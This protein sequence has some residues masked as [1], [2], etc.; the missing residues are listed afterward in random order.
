MCVWNKLY[1]RN[2]YGEIEFQNGKNFEDIAIMHRI[3]AMAERIAVVDYHGYHYRQR[4]DSI[5]LT[6]TASNLLDYADANLSRYCYFEQFMKSLFIQEHEKLLLQTAIGISRV[7]RWWYGCSR[8]ERKLFKGQ[9]NEMVSFSRKHYPLFGFRN[10]PKPLR[11]ASPF[12]HSNTEFS[13]GI[14]YVM[15]RIF[16]FYATKENS[17]QA[18]IY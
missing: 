6:Y 1:H 3:I 17:N 10:W 9:I 4:I 18:F 12:I 11:V 14:L 15:N 2:L 8:E 13:F 7:W 5:T 16:R